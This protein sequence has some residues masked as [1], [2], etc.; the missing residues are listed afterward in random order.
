MPILNLINL[1]KYS[2]DRQKRFWTLKDDF[3]LNK[4][5]GCHPLLGNC[6]NRGNDFVKF[7][8]LLCEKRMPWLI[9][10][11]KNFFKLFYSYLKRSRPEQ[12]EVSE[13]KRVGDRNRPFVGLGDR[14]ENIELI[15]RNRNSKMGIPT[16]S[17]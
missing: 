7:E 16:H 10:N 8:S 4:D 13:I 14:C 3:E 9:F 1:P 12:P 11:V 17:V 5:D 15:I 6:V 2:F